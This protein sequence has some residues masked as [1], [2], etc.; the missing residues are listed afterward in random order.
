[1]SLEKSING[2]NST[3]VLPGDRASL[4][5]KVSQGKISICDISGPIVLYLP[6]N[7]AQPLGMLDCKGLI[8]L[9]NSTKLYLQEGPQNEANKQPDNQHQPKNSVNYT[10]VFNCAGDTRRKQM[11]NYTSDQ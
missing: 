3:S 8:N 2:I 6:G 9:G 1:M 10:P 11:L 5:Q 4:I 7:D